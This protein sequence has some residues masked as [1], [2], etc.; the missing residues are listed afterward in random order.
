MGELV[1]RKKFT[2]LVELVLNAWPEN[3][4]VSEKDFFINGGARIPTLT[5]AYSIIEDKDWATEGFNEFDIDLILSILYQS[6]VML[7][8]ISRRV[9]TVNPRDINVR[10]LEDQFLDKTKYKF[11]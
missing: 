2:K 3:I 8:E 5:K 6:Y 7:H 9:D 4:D 11:G 1:E 10:F